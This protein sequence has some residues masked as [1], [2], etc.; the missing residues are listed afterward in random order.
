[1]YIY[2]V[3]YEPFNALSMK[4][5]EMQFITAFFLKQYKSTFQCTLLKNIT[6]YI[7]KYIPMYINNVHTMCITK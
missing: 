5:I 4:H 7:L 6:M 2:N 3:H 1:M